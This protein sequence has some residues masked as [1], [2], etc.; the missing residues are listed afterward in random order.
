MDAEILNVPGWERV[1]RFRD[2]ETGLDAIVSIHSTANGPACGGVRMRKY[3]SIEDALDDVKR[4]S[5]GMTY[6]NALGDI[7]FGGGKSVIIADPHTEKTPEL[8]QA[9]AKAV[10]TLG[11]LYYAAEDSGIKPADM[12]EMR[13]ATKFVAGIPGPNG[14]GGDPSPHTA[15]GVWRGI[16]A[17]ARRRFNV[18]SL[19]GLKVVIVG[20][21]AVGM[22]LAR[23]LHEEG[24]ELIVA[25]VRKDAL[26]KAW[27]EFGA[28]IVSPEEAPAQTADIFAPCALGGAINADTIDELKV[29]AVAG[30][31]NNQLRTPDMGAALRAKN[32]L[33][34][35]DYVIN[36]AGVISV[37]YEIL[38]TWNRETLM[39]HLDRIPETLDRIFARAEQENRPTAEIADQMAK[40]IVASAADSDVQAAE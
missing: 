27:R 9:F 35:P 36:A 22:T 37:G 33:Y 17:T 19:K 32:I 38:G 6:K 15:Y 14:E 12:I 20:V 18:D 11:G 13:K 2:E 40:E 7:P 25:D 16:Q 8:L 10:D 30:A 39:K 1:T 34:A 24:A 29:G 5:E 3:A 4:L 21:G 23:H 28:V 31:A 26:E